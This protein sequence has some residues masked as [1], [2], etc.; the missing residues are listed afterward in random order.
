M[1]S[2]KFS[3][4]ADPSYGYIN[5]I[6]EPS[7]C[8]NSYC[9]LEAIP[10]ID[11]VFSHWSDGTT[12]A[13][14]IFTQ[15]SDTALV[16]YFEMMEKDTI[17][18][19]L[20]I[21]ENKFPYYWA[22][23]DMY[24]YDNSTQYYNEVGYP[25]VRALTLDY[26]GVNEV[27]VLDTTI[28]S[29]SFV[30]WRGKIYTEPD[31][32][33]D[34]LVNRFGCDS[35]LVFYLNVIPSPETQLNATICDG[36]TISLFSDTLIATADVFTRTYIAANG[37]DSVVTLTVTQGEEYAISVNVECYLGTKLQG[38]AYGEV[39]IERAGRCNNEVTLTAQ[40]TNNNYHFSHY[41]IGDEATG[42]NPLSFELTESMVVRAIF[43]DN[44]RTL[45]PQISGEQ[46]GEYLIYD[47]QGRLLQRASSLQQTDLPH[48]VYILKTAE[49]INKIAL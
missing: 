29:G 11:Y 38:S 25:H 8:N 18:D 13:H 32:Y 43:Y 20:Y 45:N 41:L 2:F 36:E 35:V 17:Y 22:L 14:Y 12:D 26:L 28:C 23:A 37:C 9:E 5:I 7:D 39:N 33:Y 24:I 44:D 30:E 34:T 31:T 16:A 6:H 19:T 49:G 40:A 15:T 42:V 1:S 4:E 46:T 10:N 47:L 27:D 21:C 3:A 48:G